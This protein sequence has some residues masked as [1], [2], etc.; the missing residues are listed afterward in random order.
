MAILSGDYEPKLDTIKLGDAYNI[1]VKNSFNQ[2]I[3]QAVHNI[4][5]LQDRV[6]SMRELCE[7]IENVVEARVTHDD[8]NI[9]I[10]RQYVL[11]KHAHLNTDITIHYS[12]VTPMWT[13]SRGKIMYM[14]FISRVDNPIPKQFM[15]KVSVP[16]GTIKHNGI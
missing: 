1:T 5:L 7:L 3:E 2:A 6:Y 14:D 12:G 8:D 13:G 9:Y 10:R 15:K 11:R 4:E 16:Y